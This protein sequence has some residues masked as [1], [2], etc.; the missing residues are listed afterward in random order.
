MRK[1]QALS[2]FLLEIIFLFLLILPSSLGTASIPEDEY[3][4]F[5][6][7]ANP[8]EETAM[9]SPN[10]ICNYAPNPDLCKQCV[11]ERREEREERQ[12]RGKGIAIL[13]FS[14]LG[15]SF[16]YLA[17]SGIFFLA[18]KRF[19]FSKK[20]FYATLIVFILLIVIFL[21]RVF[22]PIRTAFT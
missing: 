6:K 15:V 10:E 9:I 14:L 17:A 11:R 22:I 2:L 1:V 19:L 13:Y 16:L 21:I 7:Q 8:S 4:C 20:F 3:V 18:K 5:W 12:A